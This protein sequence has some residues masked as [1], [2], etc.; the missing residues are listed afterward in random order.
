MDTLALTSWWP[1]RA[2]LL[3]AAIAV[4]VL[5]VWRGRRWWSRAGLT[6]LLVLLL[7]LNVLTGVN[8]YFGYFRTVGELSGSAGDDATTL[9]AIDAMSPTARTL[10]THGEVLSVD[11]PGTR[12]HFR[13]RP[14]LVYLPP[15]WFAHNQPHLPVLMLLHGT[16]GAPSDWVDGAEATGT[17]DRWAEAHHGVTPVVVM[18]DVNGG[19]TAD[20]E[21]VDGPPGNAE[22]YLT[23]D[24]PDY[25]EH[26]FG[27]APP[28]R[29]WAIGGLSEGGMCAAMLTLRHPQLASTFVDLSGLA[30]PRTGLTNAVG[31]TV[32]ALFHGSQPQFDAHEPAWLLT[33]DRYPAV[34]G[35][36]EAGGQDGPAVDAA[37]LLAAL[38]ARAG[39][40]TRLTVVPGA[41]HT[42][43]LWHS[44]LADALPWI[45]ARVDGRTPATGPTT[46]SPAIVAKTPTIMVADTAHR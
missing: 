27:V 8:A 38:S 15:A 37:R 7:P 31:G 33:H 24:V 12:S 28:G 10:P 34:A 16:P 35:W 41:E 11:I 14:A 23:S 43:T 46:R 9:A 18:P 44:A 5:L 2:P 40:T 32:S 39:I 30:G 36:F 17:L 19:F 25:V 13:T 45:V 3:V 26:K 21:C 4:V 20:T 42:F 6:A 1:L 22:T 29:A